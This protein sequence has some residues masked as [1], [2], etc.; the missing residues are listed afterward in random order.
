MLEVGDRAQVHDHPNEW[1]S[2]IV[3][4]ILENGV[5]VSIDHGIHNGM[6]YFFFDEL[7]KVD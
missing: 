5:L 6:Y 3:T 2:G 4:V 7:E 1:G